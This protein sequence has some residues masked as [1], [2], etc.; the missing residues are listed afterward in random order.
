MVVNILFYLRLLKHELHISRNSKYLTILIANTAFKFIVVFVYNL[1]FSYYIYSS[2]I[3]FSLEF[4]I[5]I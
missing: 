2:N 1:Y 4:N 5:A 3:D